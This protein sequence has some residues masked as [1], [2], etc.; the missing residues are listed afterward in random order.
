MILVHF[1]SEIRQVVLDF[2]VLIIEHRIYGRKGHCVPPFV[3]VFPARN[4]SRLG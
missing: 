1:N 3:G 4:Q 2:F